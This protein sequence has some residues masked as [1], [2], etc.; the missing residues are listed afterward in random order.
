MSRIERLKR[1]LIGRPLRTS[2]AEHE[3]L[4]N[5]QALAIMASDAVSSTAYATEEILLILVLAGSG[6][7]PVALPIAGAIVVL[8]AIVTT[9]YRQAISAY[10]SGGG[11]YIVASDNLGTLPALVAGA[12]LLV[13]Y[14]LTVAV[15]LAAGVA[16]ITSAVPILFEHRVALGLILLAL[17]T[18]VNLRGARES[19]TVFAVPTYLFIGSMLTLIVV[20]LAAAFSSAE[21]LV[22]PPPPVHPVHGLTL[23]LVLR[24]FSSGCTA[25][26][27]VEAI[28]NSVLSFREPRVGNASKTLIRMAVVLMTLFS[29]LTLLAHLYG[30]VPRHAETVISQIARS[31]FGNGWFYYVIQVSTAMILVLASNTSFTGFPGLASIMAQHRFLPRQLANRGDR[32]VFTNSILLLAVCA[33]LL[34]V[35]FGG[36]TSALIPLYAVG[37]FLS[38]TLAQSGLVRFWLR[39]RQK[40]WRRNLAINGIGGLI[41]GIVALV[42]AVTKF[43]TGAWMVVVL[44]PVLVGW[45][46][47]IH[48][49][50]E[51]VAA[52]LRVEVQSAG[53]VGAAEEAVRP[54]KHS[55][56]VPVSGVTTTVLSTL[57]YARTVSGQVKAVYVALDP[58]DAEN[59]RKRWAE[60]HTDIELVVLPSPYRSI[61]GPLIQFIE[62]EYER[63]SK[64]DPRARVT[65]MVPEFVLNRWWHYVLHNQTALRL[66]AALLFHSGIVVSSVPY[67]LSI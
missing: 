41:T 43:A 30:V 56:I 7:L 19:G 49:H 46:L 17:L 54:F 63:L 34:L 65:V 33:A 5:L 61:L 20:G 37:V 3:R 62:Q 13:D 9:S 2:E 29:G 1:R 28:S 23:F 67:H 66:K 14:T 12:A 32:L 11:A 53:A 42:I 44:I 15:S 24:A 35:L 31:V 45:F 58:G 64:A 6:A 52:A 10:P 48:R 59:M 55:V 51:R 8:I 47:K 39:R 25:L 16:A 36:N 38:F 4:G 22:T 60:L 26:T 40:G 57:E 27:G 50:Y 21:P 18:A